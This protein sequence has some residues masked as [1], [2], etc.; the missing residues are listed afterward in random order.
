MMEQEEAIKAMDRLAREIHE[1]YG[2]HAEQMGLHTPG[3]EELPDNAKA[4]PRS[5]SKLVLLKMQEAY[6]EGSKVKGQQKEAKRAE[7]SPASTSTPTAWSTED[8][9]KLIERVKPLFDDTVEKMRDAKRESP[10]LD[11]LD[12]FIR[13]LSERS[14]ETVLEENPEINNRIQRVASDY[15]MSFMESIERA[16]DNDESEES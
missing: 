3:W 5:I 12:I 1:I 7:E 6:A 11:G 15:L 16:N 14:C 2:K 9:A 8:A 4:V 10:F 13:K